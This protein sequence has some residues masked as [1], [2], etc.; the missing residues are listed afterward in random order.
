MHR[1]E[2]ERAQVLVADP[3]HARFL[4]MHRFAPDARGP[5]SRSEQRAF[6]AGAVS[7]DCASVYFLHEARSVFAEQKRETARLVSSST[8]QNACVFACAAAVSPSRVARPE[9]RTTSVTAHAAHPPKA[10]R[11]RARMRSTERDHARLRVR[12]AR[13]SVSRIKQLA[14]YARND[15]RRARAIWC[16]RQ[17]V[18]FA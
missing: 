5:A 12:R 13:L 14:A 11:G 15:L 4:P 9:A 3:A 2:N 16:I 6:G 18:R 7:Q 17:S 10:E 1:A 8:G